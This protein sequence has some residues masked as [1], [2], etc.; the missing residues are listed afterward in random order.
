A[1]KSTLGNLLL[2]KPHNNG[3]FNASASMDSVTKECKAETMSINGKKYTIVDTP[4]IFDTRQDIDKTLEEIAKSVNK[5]KHGVKA[6]LIVIEW[7]RFTNEQNEALNKLRIFLGKDATN[8]IIVV[9]SRAN[10]DHIKNRNEMMRSSTD[11]IR[12]F[13]Q[14]VRNRWGI[15]PNPYYPEDPFYGTLLREIKDLINGMQGVYPTEQLEKNLREQE[16]A[17]RRKEEEDRRKGQEYEERLKENARSE[18][19]EKYRKKIELLEQKQRESESE[20]VEE[21]DP[22]VIMTL[23]GSGVLTGAAVLGPAGALLGGSIG[24]VTGIR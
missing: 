22:A 15:S 19:E 6:I 11:S 8:H 10:P 3:T 9:F 14:N 2:G 24:A 4:G 21:T 18:A 20:H 17:R 16:E 23:A 7:G 1:G 12:S 13:I 5:I